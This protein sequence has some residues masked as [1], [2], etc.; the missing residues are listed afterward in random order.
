MTD[1][2]VR[3][4]IHCDCDCFFAAVEMRDDPSLSDIP[5]AI[6]GS[7][8]RRGVISTCN[9]PARKFGI[10]SAM[11]TAHAMKLCPSLK[12]IPGNMEKYRQ[13]S[14]AI[15]SIYADY[16]DQIEPLSLD[17]AYLDVTGSTLK[18][19]S[20]TFIAQEIRQRVE[21]QV[22]ITISAGVAPNKFV[23]KIASDWHKPDGLCVITPDQ[24]EAFVLQLPVKKIFGVGKVTTAKLQQMG[25]ETC[26]DLRTLSM[27]QLVDRFGRFGK[28][29][30]ELSRGIDDRP[31]RTSRERKS[32]SVEHTFAVDL[33]N[34]ACCI[35]KLPVMLAELAQRFEKHAEQREVAGA[36][37]KLK[38][39]DF[40]QTTVEQSA[41]ECPLALYQHLCQE[42]WFRGKKAVRLIGVGYRL[43]PKNQQQAVQLKLID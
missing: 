36:V 43:Q 3:K 1:T 33:P 15:M 24:L 9:Y 42:A 32:I 7:S 16:T 34:L 19:G 27:A 23:A 21:E 17:E 22:G 38:F 30:Y 37:I 41:S 25:I 39:S 35:E 40:S 2:L 31:V 29:L 6:G 14:A 18:G 4:I 20:A 26:A 10:H 11:A 12:V 13:A 8:D 5:L 28:R